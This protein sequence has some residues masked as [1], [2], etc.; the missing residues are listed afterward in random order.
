[1]R[2][3]HFIFLGLLLVAALAPSIGM[4]ASVAVAAVG[5][6][7]FLMWWVKWATKRAQRQRDAALAKTPPPQ[8]AT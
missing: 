5:L 1:M 8:G 2:V 6:K 3:D 4:V 7:L